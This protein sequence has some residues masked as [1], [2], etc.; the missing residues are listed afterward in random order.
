MNKRPRS[1]EAGANQADVARR[2]LV[3]LNRLDYVLQPDLSV[4]VSRTMKRHFFQQSIYTPGQRAIV[5]LNS[6]AEYIDLQNS[7][8]RFNVKNE[9]STSFSYGEHG[10]AINHIS[11]ILLTT[12]SGDEIERIDEVGQLMSCLDRNMMSKDWID[13]HGQMIGYRGAYTPSQTLG[14]AVAGTATRTFV[15]P[16]S[17]LTGFF[18]SFDRLA[19]SMLMSGL[20]IEIEFESGSNAVRS[21]TDT[22]LPNWSI[23][24]PEIVLDSYMLTDS[25]QRVMNEEAAM[26]GLELV[27]SSWYHHQSSVKDVQAGTTSTSVNI[28]VRKAVS[29]ALGVLTK[30][31]PGGKD[32]D[33]YGQDYF[34][35]NIFDTASTFSYQLRLGSLYFP[36]QPIQGSKGGVYGGLYEI[37]HHTQRG[38]GK[39]KTPSAPTSIAPSKYILNNTADAKS[40]YD[41]V[42]YTDLERSNTQRL[43]GVPVNNSRV[44]EVQLN[45]DFTK[46][47]GFSSLVVDTYLHY[48]R[49]A[50]V[51]LQNTEIEE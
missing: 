11:R 44:V 9:T 51:F 4:C 33:K 3:S 5:I 15:I 32:V 35:S 26:R 48:V 41:A 14:E 39:L 28:E 10:S 36:H 16:L 22:V 40:G 19:P 49:L 18:K 12:R 42:I 45:A 24:Q 20:R 17:C 47:A 30:I 21:A 6:G 37:Y 8:L 2:G 13:T 1:E 34:G 50:R 27:F 31:R 25:I 7:Y 46:P 23:Q 38:F 29:R 43:T